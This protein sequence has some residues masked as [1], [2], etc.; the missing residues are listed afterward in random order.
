[1]LRPRSK[2]IVL[3][4]AAFYLTALVLG[5]V[6]SFDSPTGRAHHHDRTVSHTASCLLACASTIADQPQTLPLTLSLAF[7]GMLLALGKPFA[8]QLALLRRQSRAPPV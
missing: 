8:L 7:I 1:M 4:L 5:T 6:C 3:F 2:K